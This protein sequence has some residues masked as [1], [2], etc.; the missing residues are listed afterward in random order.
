MQFKWSIEKMVVSGDANLVTN[1]YWHCEATENGFL[2]GV[3]GVFNLIAG[4]SFI[5]YDQLTEQQVWDWCFAPKIITLDD[6]TTITKLFKVD[7][8]AQAAE[9]IASQITQKAVEPALPWAEM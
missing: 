4:D 3:S 8:E 1:V 7:V 9:Q 6:Q 5:P 2:T